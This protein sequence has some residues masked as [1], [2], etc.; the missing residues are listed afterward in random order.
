MSVSSI[1]YGASVLGQSVQNLNNQLTNLS[2]QLSTGVKSTT[3]AG[4]GVNEGFA[5]AARAQ[6]ANITAFG[7]T[8]T[9]VNTII[10]AANTALQ[11]LSSIGSQVQSG[12]SSG[13]LDLDSNGLTVAQ[14]SAASELS[15]IV[16]VLN[17]QVGDRYIFSGSAINTPAVASADTIMNGN[18]TQAG[19]KQVIAERQQADLGTNGLGRLVI[20]SPTPTSVQLAEDVAGSPFGLK[21]N[22][23]SSTLTGASV[24]G[25]SG[26]PPAVS[27]DLGT[28]NP[29]AG[30]QVSFTFNLP[31]GTTQT[32]QLTATTA[33]PP[34]TGSFAIG[35]TPTA[36]AANL[37]AALTASI[38]T[39]ANTSLV[40]ASAVEAGDNFFDTASTATGSVANNQAT[41]PAPIT[42]ATA[43]SGTAGTDSLSAS[44]APGD[45]ITVN[46][47]PI[48]FVASGAI[49]DE[50]NVTDTVQTLL[51][52]IDSITGTSN[53]STVSGGV[54]NLHTDNAADLTVTSSNPAAFAALGFSGT[55]T[56]VQPP[57]R[58]VGSPQGSATSLVSGASNTIAWYTGNS[59]PGSARASSTARIDTSETVDFGAQ[60]N[61]QAIRTQ[62]Q[63]IAVFAAF[64]ASPTGTNSA[65]QISALSQSIAANLTPQPGQQSIA[66][67]QTDFSNAQT[68]IQA[69]TARQTQTQTMMQNMIDQTENVSTDQVASELLAVQNS[70]QASYQATSML[71]QLSL[72]RYLPLGG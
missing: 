44:F 45:T 34:P 21:L 59:G 22:A 39:L 35:A 16:G 41:P 19:L 30:D 38:T 50:V 51:A 65:A 20:S 1:N 46:G 43:L 2:T 54:I 60:A 31:D 13:S 9:N 49:G 24:T 3:Y 40:A 57:L 36:T 14:E 26:S 53:S 56:A 5:I 12:A 58:V 6:L 4:M 64:K 8:M 23:V 17:T 71:S 10:S 42:G 25:P 61:E 63:N 68:E 29:N 11:T 52:K 32:I 67:I 66:D 55:A 37:N 18:G 70:L 7:T 33:T 62:L 69:A 15:A 28:T 47:T 48:T 72:V 27:V